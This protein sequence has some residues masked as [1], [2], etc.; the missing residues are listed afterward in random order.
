MERGVAADGIGLVG[1]LAD[2]H[3]NR[4]AFE[5]IL[6]HFTDE[7]VVHVLHAG[8]FVAPFNARCL[9]GISVPFTGVFGNNDGERPGLTKAFAKYGT[10]HVGPYA[11]DTGG[12]R[13][14]IMHEPVALDAL[15]VSGRFDVVIYGHTHETDVRKVTWADGNGSTL[16]LNPGEAGGW[17]NGRATAALLDLADLNVNVF[18]VPFAR[19]SE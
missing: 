13:I 1:V 16:I 19:T 6:R 2:S 12:R 18:D 8:D 11:F 15:A 3:D 14:I 17:L 10:L 9:S 4:W 5:A 7:G